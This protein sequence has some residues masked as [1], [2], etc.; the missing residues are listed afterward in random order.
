MPK[1]Q[2]LGR[3]LESL[4]PKKKAKDE[5]TSILIDD[6]ERILKLST[7]DINP[8]PLQPRQTTDHQTLED[9]INSIK[10]HGI[11]QPLIVS[12]SQDGYQLIAGERRLKAAKIIGLKNVPCLV[13]DVTHQQKLEL[14][15]VENLQRQDLNAIERAFAYQ[16]L[17]NEFNLTQEQVAKRVGQGRVSVAQTLRLLSLPDEIKKS[18]IEGKITEGHAKVILSLPDEEK[19]LKLWKDVLKNE[20]TVRASDGQA[21][22]TKVKAFYRHPPNPEII[23]KEENLREVL[24]TRVKINK[25]G[26]RGNIVIE[27]YSD[28]DLKEII[29]KIIK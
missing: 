6:K 18:L 21:R 29:N 2:G 4:I 20:L 24:G 17:M 27:F 12:K 28:Q 7:K 16:K 8:N 11:L 14:A 26:K 19:Q 9:L 25:K 5:L 10:E 22:K 1:F 23:E 3:G 15:L 13:R